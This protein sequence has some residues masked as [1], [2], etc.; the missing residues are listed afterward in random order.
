MA[1]RW[2]RLLRTIECATASASTSSQRS[3]RGT[4]AR[5]CSPSRSVGSPRMVSQSALP[6]D[7]ARN[8]RS[9]VPGRSSLSATRQAS[10]N[11]R[12]G[13][14]RTADV[15]APLRRDTSM[16]RICHSGCMS[17]RQSSIAWST[18][19][20]AW[21][22]GR[23]QRVIAS[24]LA[25]L[26]AACS[27]SRLIAASTSA[28][29]VLARHDADA[30]AQRL[31]ISDELMAQRRQDAPE[32][33]VPRRLDLCV[34][35]LVRRRRDA[36]LGVAGQASSVAATSGLENRMMRVGRFL[37]NCGDRMR[38]APSPA[39]S[40]AGAQPTVGAHCSRASSAA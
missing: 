7:R 10:S 22:S 5:G 23:N 11:S 27:P 13:Q 21:G 19:F 39:D 34:V 31:Q 30:V 26:L 24:A 4:A 8:A 38:A 35:R 15:P 40:M 9:A 33:H 37:H 1:I 20:D 17:A 16:P 12:N 14:L 28:G 29:S 32:Q 18:A 36:G 6:R 25:M 3:R 2:P